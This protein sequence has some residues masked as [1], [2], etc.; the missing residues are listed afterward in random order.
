[1]AIWFRLALRRALLHG[2]FVRH[3]PSY[4]SWSFELSFS[5][6][7]QICGSAASITA[8][9]QPARAARFRAH[10]TQEISEIGEVSNCR[11]KE[12]GEDTQAA[13]GEAV[14][15]AGQSEL[16]VRDVRCTPAPGCL[17]LRHVTWV[18][19]SRCHRLAGQ[20]PLVLMAM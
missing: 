5:L 7:T 11:R 3:N 16:A 8:V 20:P 19:T 12:V 17:R 4:Q 10:T 14:S 13:P 15:V 9:M 6:V 18:R 1:M 2:C